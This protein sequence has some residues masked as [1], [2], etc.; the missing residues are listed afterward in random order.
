MFQLSCKERIK[1]PE[2]D[3][4]PKVIV[5]PGYVK[6]I[7]KGVFDA[8]TDVTIK[9]SFESKP[10]GWEDGWNGDCEVIWGALY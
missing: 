9:T 7:E 5:I 10:E 3:F 6:V 4:K 2:D 1:T 8:L